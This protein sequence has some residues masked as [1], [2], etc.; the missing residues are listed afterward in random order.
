MKLSK[1][2]LKKLLYDTEPTE[3]I[4]Q[5]SNFWLT[6]ANEEKIHFGLS[7]PEYYVQLILIYTGEVVNGGHFQYYKNRGLKYFQDTLNAC[8]I[9]SNTKIKNIL[10]QSSKFLE[11]VT[12]ENY[13]KWNELDQELYKICTD[14]DKNIIEFLIKNESSIL[15]QERGLNV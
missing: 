14:I 6:R 1:I 13:N 5:L 11:N 8:E 15:I 3:A 10:L 9:I 12:D 2:Y 7:L 4:F